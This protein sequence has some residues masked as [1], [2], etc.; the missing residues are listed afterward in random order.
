M[1][2][3]VHDVWS[4]VVGEGVA[5]FLAGRKAARSFV[6]Q[7]FNVAEWLADLQGQVV[8]WELLLLVGRG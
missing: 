1:I 7:V 5:F 4:G 3:L 2:F 8:F 6:G